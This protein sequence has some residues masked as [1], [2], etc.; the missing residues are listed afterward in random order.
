MGGFKTLTI[1]K[2]VYEELLKF[3]APKE[4]FS[5][6]FERLMEKEKGKKPDIMD[7]A[8]IKSNDEGEEIKKIA[9][10]YRE[11]GNKDYEE[12]KKYLEKK[13]LE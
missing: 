13:W 7:F 1:K 11:K 4:S 3:K 6:L 9:K 8:G 10:V 2:P 12:R 5:K